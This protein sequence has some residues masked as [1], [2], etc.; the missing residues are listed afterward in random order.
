MLASGHDIFPA[1]G[2]LIQGAVDHMI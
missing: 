2:A 1:N